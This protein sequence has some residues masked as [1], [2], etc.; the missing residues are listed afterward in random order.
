MAL[1]AVSRTF[2]FEKDS[3]SICF[4][5]FSYDPDPIMAHGANFPTSL[6]ACRGHLWPVGSFLSFLLNRFE[7]V[8]DCP[9]INLIDDG[10][11]RRKGL[12][13]RQAPLAFERACAELITAGSPG[14]QLPQDVETAEFTI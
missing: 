14:A 2:C 3:N 5:L 9:R 4:Q 11:C 1:F 12:S 6:T 7:Q 8:L 10:R 13:L